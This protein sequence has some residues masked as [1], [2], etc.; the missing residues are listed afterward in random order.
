V[1]Q[2]T[3]LTADFVTLIKT[4]AM[5]IHGSERVVEFWDCTN[6]TADPKRSG[7]R[8]VTHCI[9]GHKAVALLLA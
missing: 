4:F 3:S 5:C 9:P 7:I 6:S 8:S 1:A 2:T